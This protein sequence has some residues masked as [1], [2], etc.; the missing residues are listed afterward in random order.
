MEKGNKNISLMYF[1]GVKQTK[2]IESTN[3][4]I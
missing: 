1:G 2:I 4:L 3:L